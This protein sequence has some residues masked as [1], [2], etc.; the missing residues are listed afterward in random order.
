MR[1]ERNDA[2]EVTRL[3][4]RMMERK[5]LQNDFARYLGERNLNPD[6]LPGWE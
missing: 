2:E 1:Q 6:R 3:I 5:A 4:T